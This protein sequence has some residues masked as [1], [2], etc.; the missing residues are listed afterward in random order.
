MKR[1]KKCTRLMTADHA[2]QKNHNEKPIAV[3]SRIECTSLPEAT[4]SQC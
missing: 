3:P 4:L 2:G 1:K